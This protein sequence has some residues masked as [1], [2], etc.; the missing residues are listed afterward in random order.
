MHILEVLELVERTKTFKLWNS[1]KQLKQMCLV[2][3]GFLVV[4]ITNITFSVR[5]ANSMAK[6]QIISLALLTAKLTKRI[7]FSTN[8]TFV[9]ILRPIIVVV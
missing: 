8:V 4:D 1:N 6:M 5:N 9:V 3:E 7:T 2:G